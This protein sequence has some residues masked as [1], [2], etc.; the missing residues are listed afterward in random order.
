MFFDQRFRDSSMSGKA[1]SRFDNRNANDFIQKA[2]SKHA[3]FVDVLSGSVQN[4]QQ[5]LDL[6]IVSTH[7]ADVGL[8]TVESGFVW[9]LAAVSHVLF[10]STTFSCDC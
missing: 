3:G 6:G 9:L 7:D 5:R 8:S 1:R 2:A 10:D 4:F